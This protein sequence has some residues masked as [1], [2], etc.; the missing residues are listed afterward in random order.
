MED[1]PLSCLEIKLA[2][3]GVGL[4]IFAT[5]DW[6][7]QRGA[8]LCLG[9]QPCGS[10][11]IVA[12]PTRLRSFIVSVAA[13][14]GDGQIPFLQTICP[15]TIVSKTLVLP[16]SDGEILYRSCE[17]TIMSASFPG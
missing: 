15:P 5:F 11:K 14:Y 7:L 9:K 10:S 12:P 1:F 13:W 4:H 16:M 17:S 8:G 6:R 2:E 3:F